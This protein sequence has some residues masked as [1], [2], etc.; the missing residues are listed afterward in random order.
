LA[1]NVT[2]GAFALIGV[3]ARIVNGIQIG[4]RAV[5]GAGSVVIESVAEGTTV[6]GSPARPV[7]S[8]LGLIHRSA[9]P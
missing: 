5:V 6:V 7:R 9:V 2:I 1:G 4:Q 3:G 8:Q